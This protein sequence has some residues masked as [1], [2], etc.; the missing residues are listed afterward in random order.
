MEPSFSVLIPDGESAFALLVLHCFAHFPNVKVHVLSKNRWSPARFS[1][2]QCGYVFRHSREGGSMLDAVMDVARRERIDV[3]LPVDTNAISFAIANRETLSTSMKIV[4]LPDRE[5]FEIVNNKW[6]LAQYLEKT[7]MPGPQTVLVDYGDQFEERLRNMRFPV[8]LKPTGSAGGIGILR[9]DNLP[10]LKEYLERLGPEKSQG[11]FIVQSFLAGKDITLNVLSRNGELLAATFQKGLIP[12][13]LPFAPMGAVEFVKDDGFLRMV[14]K[15]VSGLGWNGWAC[16][17]S[18]Y[19]S[20]GNLRITDMNAR[21]WNSLLGS[22][23]A[24]V[25]FPYLACLVAFGVEFPMPD[26]ET[27]RYFHPMTFFKEKLLDFYGKG[28]ERDITF[29]E[30]GLRFLA[31]DPLAEAIRI[32]YNRTR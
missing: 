26:F 18:I 16:L 7:Q 6:S 29:K 21:F 15:L 32:Y 4:P 3:L 9:F 25:S 20:D 30:S 17:D 11:R 22:L 5:S 8:L 27:I 12:N 24:G 2:Y 19:E 13:T 31:T 14:Q 28:R 10:K 1:R 23:E